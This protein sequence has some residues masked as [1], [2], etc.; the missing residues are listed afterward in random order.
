MSTPHAE[1]AF[2]TTEESWL[3]GRLDGVTAT[4]APDVL[5]L[6][7]SR[8][9][10]WARKCRLLE[11]EDLSDREWIEWGRRLQPVVAEAYA[12]RTG[13]EVTPWPAYTL[14]RSD[15][16][17]WMICTPDAEQR[18]GQLGPG[19]LEIKTAGQFMAGEWRD[20][21]PL[22]YQVQLQHQLA[23]LGAQW[24]TLCCLIGGQKL[25][26]FDQL[27]NQ[28]FIEALVHAEAEFWG[29]VQ[30]RDPPPVDGT[31]ATREALHRLHPADSG[32]EVLLP[33]AAAEWDAEIA[34]CKAEI[35]ALEERQRAAEN[36]IKAAMG[37]ASYGHLP[38][39]GRW[40]WCVEPRKAHQVEASNPRILRRLSK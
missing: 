17:P 8:Y 7:G 35:K 23:V 4:D 1:A 29:R 6:R 24:G 14:A 9:E 19:A 16:V 27:A 11:A 20:G 5:G 10:L 40:K 30:R 18:D 39:G 25:V 37:D 33:A 36:Q 2:V 26:W 28:R 15:A 12:E 21:P 22:A 34:E 13:R 3:A 31:A 38:G 32:A